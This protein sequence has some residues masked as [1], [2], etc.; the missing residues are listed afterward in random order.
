MLRMRVAIFLFTSTVISA[1][2]CDDRA[3][4]APSPSP[5]GVSDEADPQASGQPA[6]A[7]ASA[8]TAPSDAHVLAGTWTGA[9]EAVKGSVTLQPKVEDKAWKE[10]D[11][12]RVAG[13]GTVTLVVGPDG[14]VTGK[15]TGALGA[16]T[17]RGEADAEMVRATVTPDEPTSVTA[18]TGVLV[19]QRKGE[20]LVGRIRVAGPDATLVRESPIELR[21]E[22]E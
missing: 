1:S 6:A 18:M 17:L 14:A 8:S 21:R 11:G 16:Q 7:S 12:K 15:T 19:G 13:P 22:K 5:E 10:D 4:P 3:T 2:A 20:V 9:Y